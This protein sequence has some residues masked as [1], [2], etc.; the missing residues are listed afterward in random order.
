MITLNDVLWLRIAGQ[1]T[2]SGL[3]E[4]KRMVPG[5]VYATIQQEV[6]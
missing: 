3:Q 6:C 5:N 4:L 2:P 1:L